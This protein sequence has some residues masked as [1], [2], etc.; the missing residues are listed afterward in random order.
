[1]AKTGVAQEMRMKLTGHKSEREHQ[2]YTRQ[3]FESLRAAV[4]ILPSLS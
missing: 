4:A 2:K 1:M 3:E